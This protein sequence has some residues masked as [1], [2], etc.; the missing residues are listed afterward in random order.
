MAARAVLVELC[1]EWDIE[2]E[3]LSISEMKDA[4]RKQADKKLTR[5]KV[6]HGATILSDAMKK[7]LCQEY[8]FV[9]VD[10]EGRRIK[11]AGKN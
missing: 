8:T 3:G 1:K 7:F 10:K 2:Y 5:K 9:L 4:I 6:H 11:Y